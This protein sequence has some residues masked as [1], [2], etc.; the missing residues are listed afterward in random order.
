[1]HAVV[2]FKRDLRWHD[3]AAWHAALES[4]FPIVLLFVVEPELIT[5][6]SYSHR[7]WWFQFESIRVI[8]RQ[9]SHLELKINVLQGSLTQ[10]LEDLLLDLGPFTLFSHEETGIGVTFERDKAVKQFVKSHDLSWREF[11]QFAVQRGRRD[12]TGWDADW[13]LFMNQKQLEVNVESGTYVRISSELRQQYKVRLNPQINPDDFQVP[14][15][16]QGLQILHSFVQERYKKYSR[17]I[18]KP[19]DSQHYCSRL[20][21]YLAWGNLSLREVVQ[22]VAIG[23]RKTKNP[24]FQAALSRLHWHC[25]FIQ[26][27]E[28]D[29]A[30]EFVNQNKAYNTIRTELNEAYF[31]L[32]TQGN[33][34]FPLIDACIRCLK[35]TGYLNFRMRAMLVSFWTHHLFQPWQPLAVWMAALFLDFEPGI[36]FA[37]FQMQAGTVGYHT[38]RIY[39]PVKQAEEHDPEAVFIKKWVP[40]LAQLPNH[41]AREPWTMTAMEEMF[42]QFQNGADYPNRMIDLE[43]AARRARDVLHTIKASS[44]A[45]GLAAEI[46]KI[47]VK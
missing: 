14:G 13:D 34:G 47:H 37:Q 10:I 24:N 15:R 45:K 43:N 22:F 1:M 4:G 8:Q 12:R 7:H 6:P 33:T 25:H 38:I 2:W 40:E 36:H 46:R 17:S 44:A 16:V 27:L 18:S 23:Y 29:P 20:S 21:P 35:E 41:F 11:P 30:M 31:A 19:L 32:F 28:S 39:N 42:Y 5:H 9:F 3:H 26:K